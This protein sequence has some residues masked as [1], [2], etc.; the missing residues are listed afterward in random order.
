MRPLS[1][2]ACAALLQRLRITCCNCPN[3]P[4]T[5]AV[6]G[7]SPA[8]SSIRD[9]SEA[10]RSEVA[11][12]T[13]ALTLTGM[14]RASRRRPKA[15][16]W[17]TRSRARSPARWISPRWQAA[18]SRNVNDP[19]RRRAE[20]GG[21]RQYPIRPAR[22]EGNPLPAPGM[23]PGGVVADREIRSI[24][25][26]AFCHV[27]ESHLDIATD[28]PRLGVSEA[29][30]DAGYHVLEGGAASQRL[31]P[32]PEAQSGMNEK[33]E[34]EQRRRVEDTAESAGA[35]PRCAL[36]QQDQPMD[37]FPLPLAGY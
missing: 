15:R 32:R 3:S 17:S 16:I 31:R 24:R 10:F 22:H 9:G 19:V 2:I 35:F 34:Q 29:H 6:S 23:G 8:I 7:T 1:S 21:E 26:D 4:E 37:G 14:R 33:S 28:I 11:S 27:S 20:A 36:A 18:R 5:M 30:R 12:A 13:N 25:T